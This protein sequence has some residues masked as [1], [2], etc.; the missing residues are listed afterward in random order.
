[1]DDQNLRSGLIY[2]V[3]EKKAPG[4]KESSQMNFTKPDA[5]D[6]R[7]LNAILWQDAKGTVAMPAKWSS[8]KPIEH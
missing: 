3:N 1:V 4:A 7:K 5:V 8:P 2:K 6:A